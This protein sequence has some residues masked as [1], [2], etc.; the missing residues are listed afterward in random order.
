MQINISKASAPALVDAIENHV[1]SIEALATTPGG[2]MS[3]EKRAIDEL[4]AI[5]DRIRGRL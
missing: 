4:R 2:L 5:A 3:D 1:R